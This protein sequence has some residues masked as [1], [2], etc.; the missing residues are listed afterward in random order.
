MKDLV[1][2]LI[3]LVAYFTYTFPPLVCS[4]THAARITRSILSIVIGGTIGFGIGSALT[5]IL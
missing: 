3:M 1:L 4:K 5:T 2:W